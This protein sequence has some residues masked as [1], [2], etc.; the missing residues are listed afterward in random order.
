MK[1]Q[2]QTQL[3]QKKN[4]SLKINEIFS[5]RAKSAFFSFMQYYLKFIFCKNLSF[6]LKTHIL[7]YFCE[8]KMKNK[9]HAL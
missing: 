4:I 7:Y 6:F 8:K 9:D 5:C 3:S 2:L 1:V